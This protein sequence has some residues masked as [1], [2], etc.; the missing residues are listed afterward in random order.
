[1]LALPK[2]PDPKPLEGTAAAGAQALGSVQAPGRGQLQLG[3]ALGRGLP[4]APLWPLRDGA[5]RTRVLSPG[6]ERAGCKKASLH[7]QPR[8]GAAG[9]GTRNKDIHHNPVV[10]TCGTKV[11]NVGPPRKGQHGTETAVRQS[12]KG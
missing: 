5:A 12:S 11:S 4:A 6:P 3:Q 10:T 1:M 8:E 9:R 2:W 7:V